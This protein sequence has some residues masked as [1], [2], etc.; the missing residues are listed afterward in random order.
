[1][2]FG[3]D[4]QLYYKTDGVSGAAAWVENTNIKDLAASL[5][6]EQVDDSTRASR[7]WKS[8]KAK[9][10]DCEVTFQMLAEDTNAHYGVFRDAW[11]AGTHLGL[12][13]YD[14]AANGIEADFVITEFGHSQKLSDA[15]LADVTMKIT[16][17]DTLPVWNEAP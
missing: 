9:V 10:K 3:I 13:V 15:Q 7:P 12:R 17:V 6:S 8:T 16:Y 14:G 5:P 11:L 2:K 4:G 1:M